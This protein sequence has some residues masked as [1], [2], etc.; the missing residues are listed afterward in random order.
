MLKFVVCLCPTTV[1]C[2][3]FCL[4]AELLELS[5][6][7]QFI[8]VGPPGVTGPHQATFSLKS[9]LVFGVCQ[10]ILASVFWSADYHRRL[11][12]KF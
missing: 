4:P 3:P 7:A 1:F 2:A 8:P 10:Q 12:G 6:R 5:G 11:V 9:A